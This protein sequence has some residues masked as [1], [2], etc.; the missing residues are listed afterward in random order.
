MTKKKPAAPP[1]SITEPLRA[2]IRMSELSMYEL[3]RESGVA[4][5]VIARFVRGERDLLLATADRLAAALQ[6]TLSSTKGLKR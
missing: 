6:L 1:R 2:A 5:A 3:A 4:H